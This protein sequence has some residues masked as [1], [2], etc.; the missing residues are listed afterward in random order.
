M[1]YDDMWESMMQGIRNENSKTIFLQFFH[2]FSSFQ[3]SII[4]QN[5]L[6]VVSYENKNFV[7]H[8]TQNK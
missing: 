4:S 3:P 5:A 8:E 7:E 6:S 1:F 2:R